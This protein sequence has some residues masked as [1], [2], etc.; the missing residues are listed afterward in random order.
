M[1][2][3]DLNLA[4]TMSLKDK[5]VAPLAQVINRAERGLKDLEATAGRTAKTTTAVAEG[6][7]KIGRNASDMR[8]ATGEMRKLGDEAARASREV[9]KV[10]AAGSRMR[11]LMTGVAQ[12]VAGT[13]AF[14]HVVADPLRK[15]ADYDTSLRHLAN[16]TFAGKSLADR[17]FGMRT[18]DASITSAIRFGGGARDDGLGALNEL[19]GSGVFGEDPRAA[20]SMLPTIMKSSTASGAPAGDLATIAIRAK[21]SMGINDAAGLTD[22]FD[23]AMAAGQAGG[24]ELKDMAKWLPQQMAAARGLGMT[25]LSGMTSLLAANQ[26]SVITAGTRDEAGNNLVNLLGKINSQDAAHDFQRLGIDLP[27]TL[28][29]AS[30]HGMN[31]LDG[32]VALV[33]KVVGGDPKFKAAQ[34]AAQSAK[35]GDR[36]AASES[37]LSLLQ[38]S[39]I[40][41]V[42]QDRQALMALVALMNNRGYVSDVK[43][44]INGSKGSIDAASALITEGAGFIYDQREF[45]A[46]RAQTAAMTDANSAVTKLAEAQTDLYRR[47]P[48]YAE[49]I[50]G[51]KVAIAGLGAAA[52]GSAIMNL[53][54]GGVGAAATTQAVGTAAAASLFWP[55]VG[56]TLGGAGASLAATNVVSNNQEVF[57]GVADNA[58]ESAMSGD[59]GL[60]A[61]I[62]SVAKRPVEVNVYLD[63]SQ[64]ESNVTKRQAAEG[65]RQ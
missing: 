12:G 38:G 16:T 65:R 20:M 61:A 23:R 9:S 17:R 58:M 55:G 54:T 5:I 53:L 11:G 13:M 15:A 36:A 57:D 47:Y 46:Q 14:S 4:M 31:A 60:A 29:K 63:G 50:E 56:L 37:M 18:L 30:G 10:Q 43:S 34:Q 28:A 2:L 22:L 33:D 26:A 3:K 49:A 1:S 59:T 40:G 21:Q 42:V 64:I 35:G 24:F 27:G 25:G 7:G 62:L 48:G 52:A 44:K 39:S 51:A 8:N 41:K 32:F 19:I 6:L 45:E